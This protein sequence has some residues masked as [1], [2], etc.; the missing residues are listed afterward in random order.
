MWP[1]R[2][3]H[4]L[5]PDFL[6][7]ELTERTKS[8]IKKNGRG[9]GSVRQKDKIS[10]NRM[11]V[12]PFP[13]PSLAPLLLN[14]FLS[15]SYPSAFPSAERTVTEFKFAER[16]RSKD[17]LCYVL[18]AR[19][20]KLN[21]LPWVSNGTQRSLCYKTNRINKEQS[22]ATQDIHWSHCLSWEKNNGQ[23][24]REVPRC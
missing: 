4:Q 6:L 12:P 18:C 16:D 21:C 14:T 23:S 15:Y 24:R 1:Q 3:K 9:S 10:R 22:R 17:L 20:S 7:L 11:T 5:T 8:K 13:P 2:N 19:I